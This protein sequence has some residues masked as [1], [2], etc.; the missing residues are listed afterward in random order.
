MSEEQTEKN[1]VGAPSSYTPKIAAE[2]CSRIAIGNSLR[3]VVTDEDMPTA[4]TVYN[5]LGKHPEFVEQ[6]TRAKTDSG[7]SDA[8]KIE[9]IAEKTL[10]GTYDPAQARVAI[11]A[12]KWSAGKKRPKKYGDTL[13]LTTKGE[14][15]PSA[16]V[17]LPDNGRDKG[18]DKTHG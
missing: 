1:K 10:D 13:D 11:D 17:Y 18:K 7:D 5:W 8:D 3:K 2:L 14:A 12:Y 16:V 9:E 6:Y 4:Q 15:I